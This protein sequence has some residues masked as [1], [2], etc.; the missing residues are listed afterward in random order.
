VHRSASVIAFF[1]LLLMPAYASAQSPDR[2]TLLDNFGEFDKGERIFIFGS[3]ASISPDLF[4]ILKIVNPRGDLCQIQQLTP[5]SNGLFITESIPLSGRICGVAGDYEIKVYYG[6]YFSSVE[7][8][9]TSEKY[10]EKTDGEYLSDAQ[11]LVSEKIQSVGEVTGVSTLIYTEQLDLINSNTPNIAKHEQLYVDLWNDFFIE[12]E[13]FEIDTQFRPAINAALDATANLV[14]SGKIS[15][16][17]A[18]EIDQEIFSAV[19][20]THIGD[21]RNAVAKLN[22]VFVLIKNSDPIKVVE[23]Q[24]LSFRELEDALLNLMT[25]THSVLSGKIKEEIAFIF[26][27]GIGPLYAEDLDNML[28]LLTKT[29]FL[30]VILRNSDP[31]YRLVQ[32]QWESTKSSLTEKSTM[33]ELLE[34]KEKVDKL[35]HA[36][37]ILRELDDVDRFISS[38]KEENS[39]LANLILPEWTSLQSDLEL[40]TSVDDIINSENDILNMKNVIDAS[41]RISKAVE[42]SQISNVN[43]EITEGWEDLLAQVENA[44]TID[45][46]LKIVSDFDMSINE[47][48]EKRNPL[49]L[50]KFK[51]DAMKVKAELQADYKNLFIINNALRIIDTAQQMASGNP[52]VSKIDRIEVLLTWASTKAPE[53]QSELNSYSKDAYK[54]RASDILQRAKSIENLVDLSLRSKKFLPGYTD[55]TDSMIE[56]VD[57]ARELVIKND[58]DAADNMVRDLFDEWQQVSNAYS[59][60]PFGSEVGYSVDE[61]KRIEYRKQLD[62]LSNAVSNFY[63]ADFEPYSDDYVKLTNEVSGSIDYGNF[64]DVEKKMQEMNEYLSEYLVL[65]NERIIYDISF[66][67]EKDIWIMK[68]SVN[69]REPMMMD[70]R[71]ENLYLTVYDM[72]ANIHSTLKFKD[73]RDGDFYTQWHAPTEPG[74]YVVMLQYQNEKASQIVNVQDKSEYSYTS[75]ELSDAELA[76]D[77]EELKSFISSFGGNNLE[78]N[79]ERFDSV[80]DSI[81]SGLAD[82]DSEIVNEKLDELKRLIERYLPTRSRSAVIEAN[83]Q[84]DKLQISGA[85]QKTISFRED[86]F[87][88]IYDQRGEHVKEIALKDNT[89]GHFSETI[90]IPLGPGVYVAKLQYHDNIVSD[91]FNVG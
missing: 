44:Q 83:M 52:S 31:L 75:G 17:I 68:G 33:Q 16:D 49:S 3:I 35:H 48:R 4:L 36:A 81:K 79:Q 47:L 30:D 32:N 89:S 71:R 67:Q 19:F 85:I 63:N 45:E 13:L 41:S 2:I 69:N 87:V 15:F 34:S 51:Y 90:S 55:F 6:D 82:R 78:K 37:L 43:S 38:D 61:L 8:T 72:D 50:L 59:D 73:T 40:A 23:K 12:D 39:E 42:I 11:N 28:D 53:I 9:V 14:E 10:L 58:L 76:R 62:A 65:N 25:K 20:F 66:D 84:D 54:V 64:I 7:F 5:L 88:D 24:S 74:L 21:K 18:N 70:D 91:F 46:I 27:R 22:D 86:L 29:R 57:L 26:S 1:V 56:R 80:M 60:D 77:F